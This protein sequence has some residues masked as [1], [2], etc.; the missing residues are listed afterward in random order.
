MGIKSTVGDFKVNTSSTTVKEAKYVLD[1]PNSVT[2]LRRFLT[3]VTLECAT[4][5]QLD[6]DPGDD[7]KSTCTPQIYRCCA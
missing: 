7:G 1:V 4:L 5:R 3:M 6:N 2:A